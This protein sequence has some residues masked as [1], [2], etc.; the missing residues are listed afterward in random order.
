MLKVVESAAESFK[1][2]WWCD[3]GSNNG[4]I[5]QKKKGVDDMTFNYCTHIYHENGVVEFSHIRH[6]TVECIDLMITS[7]SF[8]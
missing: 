5:K 7:S 4:V 2:K 3:N 6:Q 1:T 8:I